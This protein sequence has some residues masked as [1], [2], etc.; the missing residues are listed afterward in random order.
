MATGWISRP[1]LIAI[2]TFG[3]ACLAIALSFLGAYLLLSGGKKERAAQP[4]EV[5]DYDG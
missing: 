5:T 4:G 1:A 3:I 2:L